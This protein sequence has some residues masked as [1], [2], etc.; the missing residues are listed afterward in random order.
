MP[1]AI[2]ALTTDPPCRCPCRRCSQPPTTANALT[3]VPPAADDLAAN[4]PT[5]APATAVHSRHWLPLPPT[6]ATSKGI[7]GELAAAGAMAVGDRRRGWW[8]QQGVQIPQASETA[9]TSPTST[10]PSPRP[11]LLP[12]SHPHYLRPPPCPRRGALHLLWWGG[13]QRGRECDNGSRGKPRSQP[14][15]AR[16]FRCTRCHCHI[17]IVP[18][19]PW[20]TQEEGAEGMR[21]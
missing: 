6:A 9:T 8:W 11:C 17:I 15:P 16:L 21:M 20:L 10:P 14:P 2:N 13:G 12:M 3:A 1:T 19:G 5:S 7:G 4:L 18:S